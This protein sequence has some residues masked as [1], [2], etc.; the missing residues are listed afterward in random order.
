MSGPGVLMPLFERFLF[1]WLAISVAANCN[2][3]GAVFCV[4]IG[5]PVCGSAWRSNGNG[6]SSPAVWKVGYQVCSKCELRHCSLWY[7]DCRGSCLRH[8]QEWVQPHRACW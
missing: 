5:T 2:R 4:R 8:V 1:D 3:K 6:A 7:V